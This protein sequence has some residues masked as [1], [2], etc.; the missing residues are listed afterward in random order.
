LKMVES[1]YRRLGYPRCGFEADR[2]V[3]G[4][5]IIRKRALKMLEIKIDFGGVLLPK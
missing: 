3:A 5:L 4:K 1:E 2:D